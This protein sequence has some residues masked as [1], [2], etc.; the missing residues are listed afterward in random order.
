M[1]MI[2]AVIRASCASG[3]QD[4]KRDR[5]QPITDRTCEVG[6]RFLIALSSQ[7]HERSLHPPVLLLRASDLDAQPR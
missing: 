4:P 1:G 5:H 7:V 6:E 3:A 2:R